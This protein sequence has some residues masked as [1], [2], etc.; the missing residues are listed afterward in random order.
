[1]K[2]YIFLHIS[3]ISAIFKETDGIIHAADPFISA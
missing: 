1:L 3:L 2:N